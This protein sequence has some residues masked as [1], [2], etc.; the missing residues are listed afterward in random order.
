MKTET[1]KALL[2]GKTV[3]FNTCYLN[4]NTVNVWED[5]DVKN[6]DHYHIF[7]S[8]FTT[9][10]NYPVFRIKPEPK[11]VMVRIALMQNDGVFYTETVNEPKEEYNL[12]TYSNY[13]DRWLTDWVIYKFI[14]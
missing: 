11:I 12:V 10:E 7:A 8:L 9:N 5:L 4:K 3:Q 6:K 14:P 13:F 2:D 1:I